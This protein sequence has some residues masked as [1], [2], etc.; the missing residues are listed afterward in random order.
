M[1]PKDRE[2][3]KKR[4]GELLCFDSMK[5]GN[6]NIMRLPGGFM[7]QYGTTS[8]FTPYNEIVALDLSASKID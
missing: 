1:T 5:V 6:V 2:E 4:V 3:L 8:T 7:Y